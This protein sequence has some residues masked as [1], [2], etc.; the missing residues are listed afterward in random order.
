[1]RAAVGGRVDSEMPTGR[2]NMARST[3]LP[4]YR[5]R[6]QALRK[7]MARHKLPALLVTNRFDHVHLTGFTGEDS[8]V[9]VTRTGVQVISDGRFAT[10]IQREVPWAPVSLRKGSLLEEIVQVAAAH[11]LKALAVQAEYLTVAARAELQR[12]LRGVK[13]LDAP[14][15]FRELRI[16]KSADELKLIGKAARIAEAAYGAMLASLRIGQTELE[17]AARLEYEM[18]RRGST[19]PAFESIVA[20]DANA[21]LPHAVPGTRKLKRGCT[22]LVDWGA[23]YGF[24]RSD[25]TRTVFIGSIAPKM[26]KVYALVLEAQRMAI[27]AIRPGERM[28]DVDAVARRHIADAG[29]GEFYNHGLGHGLGLDIHEAPSLRWSSTEAL[30]V[31]MVVTVEPGVYLPGIGGVRIEDDVLVTR[32][33][34]KVLTRLDKDLD[35]AVLNPGR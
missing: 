29:Y 18:K 15:V 16:L 7:A 33:G 25:L 14:P 22:L 12:G 20:I 24:Y 26:R 35:S 28:C 19:A 21:A 8:A 10:S 6:I 17:I 3:P 27:A 13:L 32:G 23:T 9:L 31:G 30:R 4:V 34:C 1:M 5:N 11:R 2:T